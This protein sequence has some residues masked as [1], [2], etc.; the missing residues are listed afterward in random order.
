MKVENIDEMDLNGVLLTEF[1][2]RYSLDRSR[3]ELETLIE[4][5]AEGFDHT[6]IDVVEQLPDGSY[7]RT[8]ETFDINEP[9][10]SPFWIDV[11]LRHRAYQQF[12]Q[13]PTRDQKEK[14]RSFWEE[15]KIRFQNLMADKMFE[16][17][18]LNELIMPREAYE[19]EQQND[20]VDF[21]F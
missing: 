8:G 12:K 3:E 1:P 20:Q 4:E 7:Q 15:R 19:G 21:D 16:G 9:K 14:I 17:G 18:K 10:I 13:L 11:A 5:A 6:P 2:D